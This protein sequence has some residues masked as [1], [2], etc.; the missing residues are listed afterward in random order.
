[1]LWRDVQLD[2]H[3]VCGAPFGGPVGAS[4]LRLGS[5]F[6]PGS[7]LLAA[8]VRDDRKVLMIGAEEA[9]PKMRIFTSAGALI[10]SF[11]VVSGLASSSWSF[12]PFSFVSSGPTAAW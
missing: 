3:I 5:A 10:S 2:K 7:R 9:R 1:M 11:S 8:M 6:S 12:S 4:C